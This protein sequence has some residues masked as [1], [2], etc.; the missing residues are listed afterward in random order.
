[1]GSRGFASGSMSLSGRRRRVWGSGIQPG[2][3]YGGA[4][5]YGVLSFPAVQPLMVGSYRGD[6]GRGFISGA[7]VGSGIGVGL[8]SGLGVGLGSGIGASSA[9]GFGSGF[10]SGAAFKYGAGFGG[11]IGGETVQMLGNEKF[12]MK[13]LNERLA[14][15]L[16]KVHLLQ[17]ANAE[18]ELKIS[19]FVDSRTSPIARDYSESLSTISDLQTKILDAIRLNG[20]VF[21][22]L[23]N[24]TLAAHDFRM[25][26]EYELAQRQ[27]IEADISVLKRLLDELNL[28]KTE[29]MM[30]IDTLKEDKVQLQNLHREEMVTTR[31]KMSGQIHVEVESAPQQ[32]LTSVLED[33]RDHYET[34]ASKNRRDLEAWFKGKLETL[35]QEVATTA[36]TVDTSKT[37]LTVEKTKVQSLDLELQSVLAVKTSLEGKLSDVKAF[38]AVQLSGYQLRVTSVE[39]QLLQ[40][41]FDLERQSRDY[42]M[43]LDIKTRLEIEI[44]EYRRLLDIGASGSPAL[45]TDPGP[46]PLDKAGSKSKP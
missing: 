4:G 19:Q 24:A 28:K 2:N 27:T 31:S 10:G 35:K 46:A 8:G 17:K 42:Q 41:R 43:L 32:D 22:S 13:I 1:M 15:Y 25:K 6:I 36:G 44:A 45:Q 38:Y 9:V 37:D 33:M 7:G 18:L 26:Y 39:E 40:L 11:G 34:I 14:S 5:G 12:T 23:D 20:V 21:V 16:K 29:L 3:V 30:Q